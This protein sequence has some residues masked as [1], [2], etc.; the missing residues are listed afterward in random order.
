MSRWII[1]TILL[2]SFIAPALF[3]ANL[4][5]TPM[6]RSLQFNFSFPG[7]R[8]LGMGGA[9]IGAADDASAAESNPGG[10][11]AL[12]HREVT[13]EIR[14]LDV[15]EDI[16]FGLLGTSTAGVQNLSNNKTVL[17]FFS[18]VVPYGNSMTFAGFYARPLDYELKTT[19]N[20]P[21]GLIG[22]VG[23]QQYFFGDLAGVFAMHYKAETMGVSGAFK[24]GNLSLGAG[25]QREKL[26]AT[27]TFANFQYSPTG[28]PVKVSDTL[29]NF[30][31]IEGSDSKLAYSLGLKWAATDNISVGAAYKS[32]ADYTITE[33]NPSSAT[34]NCSTTTPG[35]SAFSIPPQYG[36]GISIHPLPM[37]MVN[38]DVVHVQYDRL[39]RHFEP[40]E[41][42]TP[43]GCPQGTDLGFEIK[44]ANEI[45]LGGEWSLVPSNI[46]LA[47]RAGWWHDPDHS[48]RY[49]GAVNSSDP[50][51]RLAQQ[52]S[53]LRYPGGK[54]Q[55]HVAVGLGYVATAFEI[56]AAY[57][58]SSLAN[59]ASISALHRF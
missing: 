50:F 16:P 38:A 11:T 33:C 31:R 34:A 43:A 47:I 3:G 51:E 39:V 59:T 8:S 9:F 48:L 54:S 45:H 52:Y 23:S 6:H 19:V 29:V 57:D 35:P 36:A 17:S 15:H 37:L 42:C 49:R 1:R 25:V 20:E 44:N 22:P 28:V 10:L 27:A 14:R 12:R 32:G 13:L 26:N 56:N 5:L 58:H 21:S 55:D 41:F 18:V 46:P 7:A 24:L 30:G 2:A 53:A 4:D 40:A